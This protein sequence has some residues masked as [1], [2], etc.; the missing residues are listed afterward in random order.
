M[1]IAEMW[2]GKFSG[3]AYLYGLEPNVWLKEYID[4]LN[5]SSSILFLGEGEGRNAC[6][7]AKQGHRC[8]AIDAS[9]TGL[10]KLD[11]LASQLN[12]SVET[13]LM[14]LEQWRAESSYDA[15]MC[16]Y[17]HLMDPLRQAVFERALMALKQEGAFVAEFFSTDQ[18]KFQSGGPKNPALLYETIDFER[19]I[20]ENFVAWT[21]EKTCV[22]LHEGHGHQ[23]PASVIRVDIRRKVR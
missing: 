5:E 11:Q 2:D 9:Q 3:E 20:D 4:T 18:L 8:T 10:N 7:A 21:L 13:R 17:L 12:V 19:L 15:I 14:D 22:E 16:S 23:G 1:S 6:Y